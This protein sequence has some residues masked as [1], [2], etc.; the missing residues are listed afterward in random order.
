M[1]P[2]RSSY[3]RDAERLGEVLIVVELLGAGGLDVHHLEIEPLG[4]GEVLPRLRVHALGDHV[5]VRDLD[6]E[7]DDLADQPALALRL[8]PDRL[9]RH[10]DAVDRRVSREH[11]QRG[12]VTGHLKVGVLE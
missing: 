6:G 5:L 8:R 11:A 3:A 2:I 1:L 10:V 7:L 4:A 9:L 12:G